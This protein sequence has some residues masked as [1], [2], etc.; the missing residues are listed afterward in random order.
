MVQLR[1]LT[2]EAYGP[3]GS[4]VEQIQHLLLWNFVNV[5]EISPQQRDDK[6]L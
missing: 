6:S 3:H 4:L 2:Q 1:D 5:C